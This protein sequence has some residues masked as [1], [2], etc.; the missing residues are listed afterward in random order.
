[1]V[2]VNDQGQAQGADTDPVASP[3]SATTV[4]HHMTNGEEHW[5]VLTG[6]TVVAQCTTLDQ[7]SELAAMMNEAKRTG[8]QF[9]PSTPCSAPRQSLATAPRVVR[10]QGLDVSPKPHPAGSPLEQRSIS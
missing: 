9:L 6:S 4:V 3:I 8:D 1:M 2:E 7:A 5:T 10:C